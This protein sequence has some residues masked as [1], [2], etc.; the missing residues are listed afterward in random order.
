MRVCCVC[1]KFLAKTV[2]RLGLTPLYVV[3]HFRPCF[4]LVFSRKQIQTKACCRKRK[5][6]YLSLSHLREGFG[7]RCC[8]SDFRNRQTGSWK[9]CPFLDSLNQLQWVVCS[10]GSVIKAVISQFFSSDER[11][12]FLWASSCS[13]FSS[14]I[15]SGHKIFPTT[16]ILPHYHHN[17]RKF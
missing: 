15:H 11:K 7:K 10:W 16:S 2:E 14:A 6:K 1:C 5:A 17:Q 12:H 9:L 3:S 4:C 8:C 13:W